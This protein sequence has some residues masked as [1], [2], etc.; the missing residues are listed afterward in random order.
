VVSTSAPVLPMI[1]PTRLSCSAMLKCSANS[2]HSSCSSALQRSRD[3]Q[4]VSAG[5]QDGRQWEQRWC[6]TGSSSRAGS[7]EAALPVLPPSRQSRSRAAGAATEWV[8]RQPAN[9]SL[10]VPPVLPGLT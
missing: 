2:G 4:R 1:T 5:Q 3:G 7:L 9:Q 6:A 10:P 8:Y